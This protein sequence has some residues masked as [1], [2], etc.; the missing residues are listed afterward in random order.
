MRKQKMINLEVYYKTILP[1]WICSPNHSVQTGLSV[2]H[3]PLVY[4]WIWLLRGMRE[5]KAFFS[6]WDYRGERLTRLLSVLLGEWC[7]HKAVYYDHSICRWRNQ[8]YVG[9]KLNQ[10]LCLPVSIRL[11]K[12]NNHQI[13]VTLFYRKWWK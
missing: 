3:I 11:C 6:R 13:V 1:F 12:E 10:L 7:T 9:S 5:V 4:T 2:I 8:V